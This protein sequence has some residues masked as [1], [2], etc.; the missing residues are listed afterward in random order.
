MAT[1]VDASPIR[2]RRHHSIEQVVAKLDQGNV[3][4]IATGSFAETAAKLGVSERTLHRWRAKYGGLRLEQLDYVEGLRREIEAMRR[5]ANN[6]ESA[7]T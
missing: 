2:R 7:R 4:H 3:Q 5:I 1:K 6:L